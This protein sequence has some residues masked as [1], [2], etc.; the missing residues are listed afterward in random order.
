[1]DDEE[2]K[3]FLERLTLK[4]W[5]ARREGSLVGVAYVLGA[6]FLLYIIMDIGPLDPISSFLYAGIAVVTFLFWQTVIR[7]P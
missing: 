3:I 7:R 1:M 4:V 2:E 5:K 6:G